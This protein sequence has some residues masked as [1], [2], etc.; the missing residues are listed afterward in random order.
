LDQTAFTVNGVA[1]PVRTGMVGE[2]RIRV[3]ERTL[4][5]YVFEPLKALREKSQ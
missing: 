3:G 2:A 5:E 1:I 4:I